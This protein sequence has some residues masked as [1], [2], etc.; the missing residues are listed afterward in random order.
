MLN[1]T[2]LLIAKKENSQA[3]Y[4]RLKPTTKS[5]SKVIAKA[6]N[7]LNAYEAVLRSRSKDGY[8]DVAINDHIADI[9]LWMDHKQDKGYETVWRIDDSSN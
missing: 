6:D 3:K 5:Q 1:T 8:A 2:L 9:K 4:T 7:P